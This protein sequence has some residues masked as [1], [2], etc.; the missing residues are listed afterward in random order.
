MKINRYALWPCVPKLVT[1]TH[2]KLI[3]DAGV[4]ICV[5]GVSLCT[6]SL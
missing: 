3:K 6:G 2:S 4:R 1:L 5:S